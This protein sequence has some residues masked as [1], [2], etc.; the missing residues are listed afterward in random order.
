MGNQGVIHF[1]I[2]RPQPTEAHEENRQEIEM[3]DLSKFFIPLFGLILAIV[4]VFL[5]I[6]PY[7]FSTLTKIFLYVLSLGYVYLTYISMYGQKVLLTMLLDGFVVMPVCARIPNFYFLNQ[8]TKQ[9]YD[10]SCN[11][12]V[13]VSTIKKTGG[14]QSACLY[15]FS[16]I[17]YQESRHMCLYALISLHV[18]LS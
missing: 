2:G 6:Y 11:H 13:A 1:H 7:V 16:Q 4:W 10:K 8:S 5:L 15:K 17:N 14:W 12:C 18:I 9:I 3:L